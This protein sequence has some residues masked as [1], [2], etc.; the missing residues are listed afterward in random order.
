MKKIILLP[1]LLLALQSFAQPSVN[2]IKRV[3]QYLDT[4][5]QLNP[6][7]KSFIHTDKDWYTIGETIW[8]K[9]YVTTDN[10]LTE[11]SKVLYV[12]IVNAQDS[13]VLKTKWPIEKNTSYGDVFLSYSLPAGNYKLRSYTLWMLNTPETICEQAFTLL[14]TDMLAPAKKTNKTETYKVQFFPEGGKWL[15]GLEQKIAFQV[16]NQNGEPPVDASTQITLLEN[17]TPVQTVAPQKNGLGSFQITADATKTYTAQLVIGKKPAINSP[18]PPVETDGVLLQ[19]INQSPTKL[20]VNIARSENGAETNKQLHLLAQING[21]VFYSADV[22]LS[23]TNAL[24]ARIPKKGLPHGVITL[25]VFNSGMQ[26]LA[27]R[28]VYN[29]VLTAPTVA[30]EPVTTSKNAKAPNTISIQLPNDASTASLSISTVSGINNAAKNNS[31]TSYLLLT[32]E[33][34]G[35]V[36]NP[37]YYLE[38]KD[39]IHNAHIDLLM[40][41]HGWRRFNWTGIVQQ[42][43]PTVQH[44]IET[45]ISFAGKVKNDDKFETA[46]KNGKIDIIIKAEDSTTIFST[47]ALDK[48]GTFFFNN[49]NFKKAAQLYSQGNKADVKRTQANVELFASYFD[50]LKYANAYGLGMNDLD[51]TLPVAKIAQLLKNYYN[52]DSASLFQG[53]MLDAVVVKTKVRTIE[54]RLTDEYVSEQYKNSDLTYAIDSLTGFT[55]IWQYLQ[56]MV[57]GLQVS[58]DIISNPV[59][60]FT[61]FSGGITDPSM[62]SQTMFEEMNNGNSSIAFFLNE[63]PVPMQTINDLSPRDIALVKVNRN[64][65]ATNNAPAGSMFIYTRKGSE[66]KGKGFSK[67]TIQGFNAAKAYFTTYYTSDAVPSQPDNRST[68]LWAPNVK[69]SGGKATLKFHNNDFATE[70]LVTLQGWDS[71]GNPFSLQQIIQPK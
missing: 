41:T 68:L 3:A 62:L 47:A 16:Y 48:N 59:V 50:T 53:R 45:G 22:N 36:Y 24:A 21:N 23:E 1:L 19:L 57:P 15:A 17:G 26:P 40:Q 30:V 11:L 29:N 64:G 35:Y 71:T 69:T 18:L 28:L 33:L 37:Q 56:G 51:T 12:D 38:A 54:Q 20:L 27:E 49:L 65:S 52:A 42:V 34:K 61:R 5:Y 60:N 32:S 6:L 70:F 8:F 46:V 25:T 67:K 7:E 39:S 66:Y 10:Q 2:T 55:S 63:I 31:L 14:S 4:T 58:G 44:F 13:V 9:A 43:Q